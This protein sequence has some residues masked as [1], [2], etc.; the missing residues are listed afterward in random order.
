MVAS[1]TNLWKPFRADISRADFEALFGK[2]KGTIQYIL[3]NP[4]LFIT[5][6]INAAQGG[7]GHLETTL[8]STLNPVLLN[9]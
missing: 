6:V 2:T 8:E 5:N 9:G 4:K 7:F 1:S 3:D